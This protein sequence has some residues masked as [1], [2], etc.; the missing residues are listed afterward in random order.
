M[1]L[2]AGKGLGVVMG[3]RVGKGLGVVMGLEP[4]VGEQ[5]EKDVQ[6]FLGALQHLQVV[7]GEGPLGTGLAEWAW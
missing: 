1:G 2:R 3:L 6:A 7:S 5:A 4:G